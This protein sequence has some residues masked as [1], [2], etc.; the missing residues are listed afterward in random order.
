MEIQRKTDAEVMAG[1]LCLRLKVGQILDSI[2]ATTRSIPA[3]YYVT[4]L[5]ALVV[6]LSNF[7]VSHQAAPCA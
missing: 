1:P 2:L 5:L 4:H 7:D 6:G 3:L